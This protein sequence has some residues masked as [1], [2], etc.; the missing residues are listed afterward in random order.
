[1]PTIALTAP[2]ELRDEHD[3]AEHAVQHHEHGE[4]EPDRDEACGGHGSIT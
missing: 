2:A 1:M 4:Q 3:L